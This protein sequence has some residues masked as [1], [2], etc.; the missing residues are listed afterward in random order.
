MLAYP[1]GPRERLRRPV[2]AVGAHPT[3]HRN[4]DQVPSCAPVDNDG[5]HD[6][7][8]EWVAGWMDPPMWQ[9]RAIPVDPRGTYYLISGFQIIHESLQ[10]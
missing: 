7:A 2:P 3:T 8:L 1:Q 6:P 9:E 10:E 5:E 4:P